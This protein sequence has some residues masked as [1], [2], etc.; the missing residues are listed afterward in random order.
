MN[1]IIIL[2]SLYICDETAYIKKSRQLLMTI[3]MVLTWEVY[4]PWN[5]VKNCSTDSSSYESDIVI[6]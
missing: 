3:V 5:S 1:I 2:L 4:Y 6:M